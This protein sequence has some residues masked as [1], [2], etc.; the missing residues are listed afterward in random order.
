MRPVPA[1]EERDM[2]ASSPFRLDWC[3]AHGGSHLIE[4]A[5]ELPVRQAGNRRGVNSGTSVVTRVL[6]V[7]IERAALPKFEAAQGETEG[8]ELQR[9]SRSRNWHYG[10]KTVSRHS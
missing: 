10:G 1:V 2:P 8:G 4:C 9:R 3:P 7:Q 6:S 5:K